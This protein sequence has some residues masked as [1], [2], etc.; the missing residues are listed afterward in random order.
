MS[1]KFE[2]TEREAN[3]KHICEHV[4]YYRMLIYVNISFFVSVH[5]AIYL[6]SDYNY[7]NWQQEH[8]SP[9]GLHWEVTGLYVNPGQHNCRLT[10]GDMKR[11]YKFSAPGEILLP[12]APVS[13][14]APEQPAAKETNDY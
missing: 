12:D 9:D 10:G 1:F 4:L 3:T 2:Q 13:T 6:I 7:I 8:T 14:K 5:Y 11:W